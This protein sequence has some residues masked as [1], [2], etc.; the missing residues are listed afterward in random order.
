MGGQNKEEIY[1]VSKDGKIAIVL[2]SGAYDRANYAL[3]I[4]TVALAMGM[5]V[6]M[7]YTYGGFRRLIKG[8]TDDLGEETPREIKSIIQNGIKKG[9]IPPI[10]KQIKEATRMGLKTYACVNAMANF[11]IAKDQL[12]SEVEKPM[13]IATFLELTKDAAKTLYV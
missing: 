6:H 13:G 9:N 10:S 4:A 3:S 2:H 11:N 5:E 7:I 8:Y 12:I 1:S